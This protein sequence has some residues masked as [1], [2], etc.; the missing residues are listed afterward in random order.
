MILLLLTTLA[1]LGILGVL[2]LLTT[3][4]KGFEET[5]KD[6]FEHPFH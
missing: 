4:A 2:L 1:I 5:Q 6:G 3:L